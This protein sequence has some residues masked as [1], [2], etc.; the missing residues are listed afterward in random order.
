[1]TRNFGETILKVGAA[2]PLKQWRV[3]ICTKQLDGI[4]IQK[5]NN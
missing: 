4:T 5:T 1:V 3:P 2:D